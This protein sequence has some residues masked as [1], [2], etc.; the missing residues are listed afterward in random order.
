MGAL[1]WCLELVKGQGEQFLYLS[2]CS[3]FWPSGKKIQN[4]R[5]FKADGGGEGQ[6]QQVRQVRLTAHIACALQPFY[7]SSVSS[8]LVPFML[9][10]SGLSTQPVLAEVHVP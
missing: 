4:V 7:D 10:G 8:M 9:E 3:T 2:S 1:N 5:H 6:W